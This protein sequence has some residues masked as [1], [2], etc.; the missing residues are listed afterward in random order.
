M[1]SDIHPNYTVAATV[2]CTSCENT[3]ETGSTKSEITT[4]LCN[5]CHP[6]YT[7]TMRILDSAHRVERFETRTAQQSGDP[8]RK[9]SEKTAARRAKRADKQKEETKIS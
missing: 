8:L 4:E 9:K 5:K 6:F 3:F 2:K 1:K 7:G